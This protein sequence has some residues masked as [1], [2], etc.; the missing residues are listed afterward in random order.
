MKRIIFL[1]SAVFAFLHAGAQAFVSRVHFSPTACDSAAS[2]QPGSFKKVADADAFDWDNSFVPE[3]NRRTDQLL[4]VIKESFPGTKGFEASYFRLMFKYNPAAAVR[5]YCLNLAFFTYGCKYTVDPVTKKSIPTG[6]FGVPSE[7][8]NWLYLYVNHPAVFFIHEEQMM[9]DGQ[10]HNVYTTYPYIGEWK[11]H[12]AYG[13]PEFMTGEAW[14]TQGNFYV[15][16]TRKNEQLFTAVTR[17]QYLNGLLGNYESQYL[18]DTASYAQS[19][20]NEKKLINKEQQQLAGGDKTAAVR[21]K[22]AED[23]LKNT[24]QIKESVLK[25][26]QAAYLARKKNV[27]DYLAAAP[28]DSLNLPAVVYSRSDTGNCREWF[29]PATNRGSAASFVTANHAYWHKGVD[30]AIPQAIVLKF[31]YQMG[32]WQGNMLKK[33]FAENF[34]M[35]KLQAMLDR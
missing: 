29:N 12:A 25:K 15:L 19:E 27:S 24:E 34:P 8:G 26:Y 3:L 4:S 2:Q 9:F 30:K 31:R 22:M 10:A 16:I 17:R 21:I 1:L 11:G 5:L 35:E 13:S 33:Q 32:S 28:A 7:T 6:A 18:A 23:D 20:L 14:S